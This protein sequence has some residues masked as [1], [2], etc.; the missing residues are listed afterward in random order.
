MENLKDEEE[1]ADSFISSPKVVITGA[2]CPKAH[3]YIEIFM[4]TSQHNK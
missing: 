2:K 3:Y 1:G 4:Q